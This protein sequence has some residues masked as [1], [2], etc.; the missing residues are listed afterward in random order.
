M[1]IAF[2]IRTLEFG[3]AERTTC[4]LANHFAALGHSVSIITI[5]GNESFFHLDDKVERCFLNLPAIAGMSKPLKPFGIIRRA[6]AIRRQV[7][8][9]HPDILIGMSSTMSG[10]AVFASLF[11]KTKAVGSE[12][13][14]PY[15]NNNSSSMLRLARKIFSVFSDGYVFQ[16][17]EAMKFFPKRMHK[18]SAIIPNAVFNPI[19]DEIK[20]VE[21]RKKIIATMG[22]YTPEKGYDFLIDTFAQMCDKIPDYTLVIYGDGIL[23][24][25]LEAHVNTL[26]LSERIIL[27]HASD[28]ALRIMAE[29]SV[30]VLSSVTEGMPNALLEAMACGVPCVSTDCPTG[31]PAKLIKSGTNGI[32]VPVN[33]IEA[34]EKAILSI[35]ND[36]AFA[37]KLAAN[38]RSIRND[39]SIDKIGQAWIDYLS[40]LL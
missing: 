32:L 28:D 2:L 13:A 26:H 39:Y 11:S 38:A 25:Q 29:A 14:N 22:R 23:R 20:P 7:K 5:G 30:F 33:D 40:T 36:K 19:I 15:K 24:E 9:I 21:I 17:S 3:G 10:Y 16:T 31:G 35:L 27:H 34:F 12:R 18:K 8:R 4:A 37:D 6:F 1:K